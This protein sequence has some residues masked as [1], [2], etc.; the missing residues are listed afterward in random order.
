MI[1]V[2]DFSD[3]TFAD[4]PISENPAFKTKQEWNS[5]DKNDDFC[6]MICKTS[7]NK[8]YS[9]LLITPTDNPMEED[10]VTRI[11]E[12]FEKETVLAWTLIVANNYS[13]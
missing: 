8:R 10:S 5:I 7:D 11:A 13:S 9:V 6:Y 2:Y 4:I 3:K 12:F 1:K